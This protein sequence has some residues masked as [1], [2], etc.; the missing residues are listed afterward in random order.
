MAQWLRLLPFLILPATLLADLPAR[1]EQKTIRGFVLQLRSSTNFQVDDYRILRTDKTRLEYQPGHEEALR[2]GS[3]VEVSGAYD[4]QQ[5]LLVAERI[6][7]HPPPSG[8]VQGM[9][10]LE[11]PPE[12]IPGGLRLLCDGRKIH[13]GKGTQLFERKDQDSPVSMADLHQRLRPGSYVDYSGTISLHGS[14]EASKIVFWKNTTEKT[15][16]RLLAAYQPRQHISGQGNLSRSLSVGKMRYRIYP[17]PII[18][19]YVHRVGVRLLSTFSRTGTARSPFA[20]LNFRFFVVDNL[21]PRATAYPSGV[22]VVRAGL[23]YVVENEAQLAF[24]LAHEIAH[25]IQEHAWR[26]WHYQRRKLRIF[27]W[28]TAYL[29]WVVEQA[30]RKGYERELE[31]QADRLALAYMARA[32]YDP[33]EGYQFLRRLE[34]VGGIALRPLLWSSHDSFSS[35]RSSIM[36]LI[37]TSH[38]DL[39]FSRLETNLEAFAA[40]RLYLP[41]TQIRTATEQSGSGQERR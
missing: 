23:L 40:A 41:E 19:G 12:V 16:A 33:R 21:Q 6:R 34:K 1:V 13:V 31:N 7:V 4:P 35:R 32:G 3:E 5:N 36:A 11:Y 39:E 30:I 25:T 24:L 15:E 8:A 17:N 38:H 37:Q 2:I 9:A 20:H 26:Q 28:A 22:V 29:S 27:R 10:I 18:Q 14:V